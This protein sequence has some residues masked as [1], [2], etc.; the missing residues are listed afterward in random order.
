MSRRSLTDNQWG[1]SCRVKLAIE[2]AV[3]PTTGFS[4][5]R[6]FGSREEH[7][8]GAI[9]HVNSAIGTRC[10]RVFGGGIAGVWESLCKALSQDSDFEYVPIEATIYKADAGASRQNPFRDIAAQCPVG[11]RE[12]LK[13]TQSGAP[14]AA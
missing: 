12:G 11:R 2:G 13:L 9:C 7:R 5:M 4:L 3:E 6:Y 14:K 1:L 10:I 8:H